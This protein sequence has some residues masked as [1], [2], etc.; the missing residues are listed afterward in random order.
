ML[1]PHDVDVVFGVRARGRV[2]D[3]G[4]DGGHAAH[5]VEP[6]RRAQAVRQRHRVDGRGGAAHL[7]EGLVEDAVAG[8]VEGFG[9]E[10]AR[11]TEVQHAGVFAELGVQQD[12]SNDATLGF[13][14]VWRGFQF[15]GHVGKYNKTAAREGGRVM[16]RCERLVNRM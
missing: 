6:P 14:A 15:F 10:P 7:A 3:E 9:R 4:L 1:L 13:A 8:L 16:N 5:G 12:G 11:Q 2:V